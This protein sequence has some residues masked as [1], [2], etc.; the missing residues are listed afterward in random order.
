MNPTLL[1]L[2]DLLSKHRDPQTMAT[3]A[4]PYIVRQLE[5]ENGSLILLSGDC[6][7]HKVLANRETFT[8]VVEHKL[9]TVLSDGMAG[10]ALRHRQGALASETALD[11]RWVS[12]GVPT[13]ASAV[14][15]PL[16]SRSVVVGLLS[17]HHSERGFFRESHLE[18]A[19]ALA[20]LIAPHFDI[21]LMVESAT[22]T[23]LQLCGA[24][25]SPC[26]V[27]D[28]EGNI[29]GVNPPMQA[30]DIAWED[31]HFS[32]S[33]LQRELSVSA[34]GEC[35]W[36]GVRPLASLPWGA[37]VTALHGVGAWIQLQANGT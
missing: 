2:L 20:Q 6:V 21:A 16:K 36:E 5:A 31:A 1:N 7:V 22:A 28:W 23:L 30:L 3:K 18:R 14:V 19:A 24:D 33:V 12:M 34:V 11:E 27:V 26:V 13:V 17:L 9:R 8:E 25:A 15:V 32:Q 4:M 29:R 10:W 35:Q 37:K